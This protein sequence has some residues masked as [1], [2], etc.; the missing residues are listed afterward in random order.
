MCFFSPTCLDAFVKEIMIAFADDDAHYALVSPLTPLLYQH[1]HRLGSS[2]RVRDI[3]IEIVAVIYYY[4][5][6]AVHLSRSNY[7][8]CSNRYLASAFAELM[9]LLLH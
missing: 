8:G 7:S 9:L 4:L 6:V 3:E 2:V 1:A 5:H